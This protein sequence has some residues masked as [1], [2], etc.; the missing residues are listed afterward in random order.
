MVKTQYG[1]LVTLHGITIKTVD[2]DAG[3]YIAVSRTGVKFSVVY[4]NYSYQAIRIDIFG[5][6]DNDC[7]INGCDLDDIAYGISQYKK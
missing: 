1:D 6:L 2:A 7:V 4:S 5:D 3:R